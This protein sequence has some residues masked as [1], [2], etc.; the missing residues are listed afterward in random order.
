[1]SFYCFSVVLL[2]VTVVCGKTIRI[3][4]TNDFH[5]KYLEV[6]ESDVKCQ[7]WDSVKDN[8]YSGIARLSTALKSLSCDVKIQAGDWVQGS[9]LDTVFKQDIAIEAYKWIEYDFATFGNHEFDYGNSHINDTV[10]QIAPRTKF[11]ASNVFFTGQGMDD[12]PLFRYV[13]H[14]NICWVSALT[15]ETLDL[16][17]V[18]DN[19][20]IEDEDSF[21]VKYINQCPQQKNVIAVTHQGYNNDI[22]TCRNVK[23]IDIIIGGHSHTNLDQG[24]YPVEVTREDGSVCYVTQTY[25]HGRYVGVLDINFDDNGMV[26]LKSH[27]YVPMDFRIKLDASVL[28]KVQMYNYQ[29]ARKAG[30]VVSTV[31]DDVIGGQACR[32]PKEL[33]EDGSYV[34]SGCSMG[35]LVC[36]AMM[37]IA[38]E[39][40]SELSRV[41]FL[42][43]GTLRNS[44]GQGKVTLRDIVNV[45]PFGNTIVSMRLKGSAILDAINHGLSVYG[46]DNRGA[47]PGGLSN[48]ILKGHVDGSKPPG[49]M[50]SVESVMIDGAALDLDRDY[51]LL[52]N[53]YI[54]TGGDGYSWPVEGL[55]WGT[56]L[57][58]ATQTYLEKNNPYP[59][60]TESR[61]LMRG[62]SVAAVN[63]LNAD[64]YASDSSDSSLMFID[65]TVGVETELDEMLVTEAQVKKGGSCKGDT[66]A[67]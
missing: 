1:M 8:C 14:H 37:Y 31:T 22:E 5:A 54:A 35:H 11:L 10:R 34:S 39:H 18:E 55:D 9:L 59:P 65:E 12:L 23:E 15:K 40:T 66:C 48:M 4:H 2:C 17:A 24:K 32:G 43:G 67:A 45:L 64:A 38:A 61:V 60:V 13:N 50:V 53:S 47:F 25:A 42:N 58:E 30:E 20:S 26:I 33:P 63:E 57:R 28:L 56:M 16:A 7:W 29:V 3:C 21:L 51:I 49:S 44:F 41:C 46:T 6:G 62:A 52:T 36:D 27:A 19:V